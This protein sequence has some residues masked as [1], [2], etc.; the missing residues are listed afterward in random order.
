MAARWTR[1]VR[2]LRADRTYR[3][4]GA[5]AA[6]AP[7]PVL[8][9]AGAERAVALPIVATANAALVWAASGRV[10]T[11]AGV[12]DVV[13]PVI[14]VCTDAPAYRT[15]AKPRA[16]DR[17]L[18]AAWFKSELPD[19]CQWWTTPYDQ[20]PTVAN[21]WIGDAKKESTRHRSSTFA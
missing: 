8:W 18:G 14:A 13:E 21:G 9:G 6:H 19:T 20:Q 3:R 10:S 16:G 15:P 2:R 17:H 12:S 11:P 4:P 1:G 7:P 5:T